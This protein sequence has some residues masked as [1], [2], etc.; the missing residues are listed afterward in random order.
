[1]LKLV[2]TASI[3]REA[4]QNLSRISINCS[5]NPVHQGRISIRSAYIGLMDRD[6]VAPSAQLLPRRFLPSLCFAALGAAPLRAQV[7]ATQ[8]VE[9]L[10]AALLD[11]MRQAQDLGA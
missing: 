11:V 1:M 6:D 7:S 9:Q 4:Q 8:P 3:Q 10:H 2:F 5:E